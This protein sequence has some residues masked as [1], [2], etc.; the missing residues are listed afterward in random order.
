[1]ADEQKDQEALQFRRD[2]E[3]F[4][5]VYANNV[6]FET[7]TFDLKVI[8]GELDQSEKPTIINQHTAISMTWVQAKLLCYF[9]QVNLAFYEADNGLI[10][11]PP[12]VFPPDIGPLPAGFE[13]NPNVKA[14]WEFVK[15][16]R[17]QLAA[18]SLKAALEQ[19][20]P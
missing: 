2:P 6:Q 1:M 9:L 10:K 15:Q 19:L 11:I 17:Q 12:A 18:S 8:F 14:V 20:K 13:D 4:S 3:S 5:S 7:S 16:L